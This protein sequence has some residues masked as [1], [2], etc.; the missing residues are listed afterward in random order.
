MLG[1]IH[2]VVGIVAV[3][4]GVMFSIMPAITEG[5]SG[6]T[7]RLLIGGIA[8]AALGV[9]ELV[10]AVGMSRMSAWVPSLAP[11]VCYPLLLALPVG[12]ILGFATLAAV[13]GERRAFLA[14]Q[15]QRTSR[16]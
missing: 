13:R 14:K 16:G 11:W 5:I 1:T 10:L 12:T 2:L 9:A 7:M 4:G 6:D 3:G 15:Q 8:V